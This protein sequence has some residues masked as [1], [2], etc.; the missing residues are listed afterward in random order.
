MHITFWLNA[1]S[2]MKLFS[3]LS[4]LGRGFLGR[5]QILFV[6]ICSQQ[7]SNVVEPGL[8][9]FFFFFFPET[10]QRVAFW[11][12]GSLLNNSAVS[13]LY[14]SSHRYCGYDPKLY[15]QNRCQP[16]SGSVATIYAL[17]ERH[18]SVQ[19]KKEILMITIIM[20]ERDRPF[21]LQ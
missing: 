18:R 8:I 10:G 15:L 13:L 5:Q 9:F 11:I 1:Y 2:I 17:L 3:F 21:Q 6:V 19:Y 14:H 7:F 12:T 4:T 16:G 20:I